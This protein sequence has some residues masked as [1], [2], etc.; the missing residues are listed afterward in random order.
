MNYKNY[1]KSDHWKKLRER[2]IS[3]SPFCFICHLEKNLHVHHKSYKRLYQENIKSLKV[4][5][6]RCHHDVHFNK[7]GKQVNMSESNSRFNRLRNMY[8]RIR[9]AES[10]MTRF[11]QSKREK[12]PKYV[13][14]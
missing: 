3:G 7:E 6:N 1:L 4:L 13:L 8:K 10:I 14:N 2:K 11:R 5:C 12:E 9:K